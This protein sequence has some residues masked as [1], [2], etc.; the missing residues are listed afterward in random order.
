MVPV[1]LQLRSRLNIY[2]L[3]SPATEYTAG[4]LGVEVLV[5]A[6]SQVLNVSNI[7]AVQISN[8]DSGAVT[9]ELVL[10]LSKK[11]NYALCRS[12]SNYAG[13]VITH[14]T[15]QHLFIKLNLVI[16]SGKTN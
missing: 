11:A 4:A 9:S 13:V 3:S 10:E 6:V 1:R 14:G 12:D 8:V 7:D 16:G 2:G 15:G 5:D